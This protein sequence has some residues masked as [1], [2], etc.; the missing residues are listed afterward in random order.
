MEMLFSLAV[1][2]AVK[3]AVILALA[4]L[5]AASWR[6]GSAAARHLVW[7]IGV[8]SALVLPVAGV[9]YA[10]AGG[11]RIPISMWTPVV[12]VT[13]E[14]APDVAPAARASYEVP[15]AMQ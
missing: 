12:R 13:A 6:S 9:I 11:P 3:S 10:W 15:S 14:I 2:A 5:I 7:T 1:S 4:G 8:V